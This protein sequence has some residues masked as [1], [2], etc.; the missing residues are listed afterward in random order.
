MKA[1]CLVAH[2]DDCVIFAYS[3]IYNHPEHDWTIGYLTYTKHDSRGQELSE[4]WQRRNIPCIFLGYVDDYRDLEN[5]KISFDVDEARERIQQL[6]KD[7]EL[8]LTH[9]QHGDYGHLHHVF[10]HDATQGH[11]R[12]VKFAG[13]D[14]GTVTLT[15][16]AGTYDLGE[17]PQHANIIQTFFPGGKHQNSYEENLCT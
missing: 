10:V 1:L 7:Y 14:S 5:K 13:L 4:F 3:Y 6:I 8:V 11:P 2:P 17:L 16:P 15:V 12:V 9:N